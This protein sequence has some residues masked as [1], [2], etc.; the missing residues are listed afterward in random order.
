M[1]LKP[2]LVAAPIWATKHY[3]WA[4]RFQFLGAKVANKALKSVCSTAFST[5]G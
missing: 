4:I 2:I 5:V 3:V 1:L